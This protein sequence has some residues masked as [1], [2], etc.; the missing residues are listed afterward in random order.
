ME[1]NPWD[2]AAA[3]LIVKEAGGEVTTFD[4]KKYGHY[5]KEIL[6]SNGKIHK[7]MSRILTAKK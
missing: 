1:L 4:G 7:E 6:A 2:T 5:L 3:W